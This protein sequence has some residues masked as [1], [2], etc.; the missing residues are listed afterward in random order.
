MQARRSFHPRDRD[1]SIRTTQTLTSAKDAAGW[2]FAVL[3]A[4]E[5]AHFYIYIPEKN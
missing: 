2:L 5:R 1:F 3:Y 4:P